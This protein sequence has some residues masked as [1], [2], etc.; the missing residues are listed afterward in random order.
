MISL[1][2][3]TYHEA[4]VIRETLRRAARTLARS[5]DSYEL[6]VVDDSSRDGTAD[7]A[8]SLAGE[9]PVRVLRRPGR[10]GLATAVLDGWGLAQ[11]EVL[12]AMDA[13]LQHPPEVLADLTR[14]FELPDVDLVIASRYVGGGS[15]SEWSLPR[16]LISWG[17]T[18]LAA[19]VLPWTLAEVTDPMSG[20]FMVRRSAIDGV[21]LNPL[22]YKILLE[23]L[24]K[25]R[26]RR[27]V[28][29]PY[30]FEQRGRGSSKLGPRQYL[31]YLVHLARLAQSTGQLGA[32][33]RYGAVGLGGAAI[34]VG[35]VYILAERAGWKPIWAV[36]TAIELALLSN[37][38]WNQWLTFRSGRNTQ[39]GKAYALPRILRYH[40]VC[41]PGAIL[42]FVVTLLLAVRNVPLVL[43]AA[44]GVIIGG[45]W[46]FV[47]NI[48]AIWRVWSRQPG[49]TQPRIS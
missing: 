17:A 36:P 5:G 4:A 18:H 23:V 1:V 29:V 9:M 35:A 43:S 15:T 47:F 41:V 14:A 34:D 13:D 22:G 33:V 25:G 26:Y 44:V 3:P 42:N 2:I 40:S 37:F 10:R 27:L 28:E 48:P 16:R 49:R 7:L 30:V 11:G 31:E 46:N 21:A 12:G 20:M 32:W 45:L 6:L 19:S 38:V 8:E 39:G 24:G